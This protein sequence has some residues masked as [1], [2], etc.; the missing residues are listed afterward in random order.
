MFCVRL[1]TCGL[2]NRNHNG[3]D[4]IMFVVA[5]FGKTQ[6]FAKYSI[7]LKR[8]CFSK[9]CR[10]LYYIFIHLVVCLTTGQKPLPKRAVHI[11]RSR[12]SSFKWE[13]PLLSLR[14][15]NSFLRLLPCLPVT[16]IPPCIFP[17]VTRCRRQFRRK[18]WPIQFAFRLHI[19]CR[20]FLCSLTLSNTSSFLTW[21]V[22]LIFSNLLQHHIL[23]LFR[24]FWSTDRSVQVSAPYKAML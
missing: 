20:I 18:M 12:A 22:Q 9:N 5:S 11:V 4:S 16:S 24:C 7:S 15:S 21:S 13:Y 14:S 3:M 10:L 2:F 1:N 6:H 23:K 19:W 8:K 17:S